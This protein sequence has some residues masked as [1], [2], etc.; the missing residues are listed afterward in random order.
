MTRGA[1]PRIVRRGRTAALAVVAALVVLLLGAG[2]ASAHATVQSTSPAE[3]GQVATAPAT[4]SVTFDEG[5][6]ISAGSIKVVDGQGR[7]VTSGRAFHPA[8][9][10]RTVAVPLAP[11]LARGAYLVIWHVVSDDSHPVS[12]SFSFGYGV[13]AGRPAAAAQDDVA[14]GVVHGVADFGALAGSV[15]LLGAVFFLSVLWPR[16]WWLGRSRRLLAVAWGAAI[17]STA[18]LFVV[19][20]PYGASRPLAEVTDGSLLAVTV[21]STYGKL[22]LL[23]LVALLAGLFV[24]RS[25]RGPARGSAR[26]SARPPSRVD[27]GGLA[28]LVVESFSFAGHA[29][30]GTWVP[31]A[32]TMDALHVAAASV[33]LG[34]LVVLGTVLTR[35][36]DAGAAADLGTVLPRW[37]RVAMAAVATLA[38]TGAY[39]AWREVGSWDALAVTAYGRLVVGKVTVLAVMLLLASYG[40]RWVAR[41]A[42]R[43]GG[44]SGESGTVGPA[45]VYAGDRTSGSV[46]VR[47]AGPAERAPAPAPVGTLRRS[48]AAEAA[49]GAVVLVLTA[50]LVNAVPG[51]QAYLP[52]FTTSVLARNSAG[53]TIRVDVL[54]RPTSPGYEGMSLRAST[55]NGRPVPLQLAAASFTN[56]ARGIGPID[57]DLATA[58]GRVEDVLISVPSPGRWQVMLRLRV[59][60]STFVAATSYAVG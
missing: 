44:G 46:L 22:L 32:S 52:S 14:L 9:D 29:G 12:G 58:A 16:G 15:V 1:L 11:G 45:A 51:R 24:W 18:V 50:V 39:Q 57:L 36:V 35:S 4:V 59:D 7:G 43:A 8:G 33:W 5:V 47:A 20:G 48:V 31:L 42:G 21:G 26:G 30:Q 38:V 34:G 55:P 54:V 6:G 3:G 17:V 27:L 23:R 10:T 41:H 28:L 2:P 13:P 19:E 49:L 60:S 53:D 56:P 40:R 37:S 25:T